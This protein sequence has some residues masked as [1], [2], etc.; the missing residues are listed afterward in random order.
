MDATLLLAEV[1][2]GKW[3]PSIGDPTVY[4]WSTVVAYLWAVLL[5]AV[6]ARWA[7]RLHAGPG[8]KRFFLFWAGMSAG[9]LMLAVNKQ[10]DLQGIVGVWGRHLAHEQGWYEHRRLVQKRF[11]LA[12]GVGGGVAVVVMLFL[13]RSLLRQTWLAILG[14][15]VTLGFVLVRA[16]SFHHVDAILGDKVGWFTMNWLMEWSGIL[17]ICIGALSNLLRRPKPPPLVAKA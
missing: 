10:L 17:L 14:V 9:L 12:I 6:C 13:M 5:C 15:G 11:I 4:G 2:N 8:Q 3:R 7:G 1:V 16:A